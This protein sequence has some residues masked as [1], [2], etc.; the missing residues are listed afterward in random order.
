MRILEDVIGL[1]YF[2]SVMVNIDIVAILYII[3]IL[4][5]AYAIF[6]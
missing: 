1:A 5:V 3:G 6:I 4:R 2:I